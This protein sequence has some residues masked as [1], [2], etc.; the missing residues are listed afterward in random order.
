MAGCIC[1]TGLG[2]IVRPLAVIFDCDGVLIDSEPIA[3]SIVASRVAQLGLPVT[4]EEIL[5]RYIGIS[6]PSMYADL[7][8]RYGTHLPQTIRAEIDATVRDELALR[9]PAMPGAA[10]ALD[11]IVEHCAVCVASSSSVS[12]IRASLTTAGLIKYF[13]GRIFS[14]FDVARGKPAPDLFNHASHKIGVPPVACVVVE[15]SFAG[16]TAARAASMRCFGFV[17]GGHA[18]PALTAALMDAGVMEIV[19]TMT[20]LPSAIAALR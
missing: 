11:R 18:S 9:V 17:G 16:A 14:A 12:R 10:D 15:D 20:R 6:A 7:E 2:L 1:V 13:E 8:K 3:C 5:E 4:Y 19:Q